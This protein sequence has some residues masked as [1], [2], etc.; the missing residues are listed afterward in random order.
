MGTVVHRVLPHLK[1]LSEF[2]GGS[3]AACGPDAELSALDE[4]DTNGTIL[5][6]DHLVA[7]QKRDQV[8]GWFSPTGGEPLSSILNDLNTYEHVH[9]IKYIPYSDN[10]DVAAIHLALQ[11]FAGTYPAVLQVVNAQALTGNEQNVHSHFVSPEGIDSN[12]GYYI[13]NGDDIQALPISR[14]VT[15]YPGRWIGWG[16]IANAKPAGL[17]VFGRNT[18]NIP[19]GWTDDGTTLKA[20][21][22]IPV[23]KGFRDW[24]LAHAWDSINVPLAPE[25]TITTGSI[26][27]GNPSIGPGSRQ[28]FLLSS[29]GWTT[30]KNV[31]LI[32][33][34]QDLEALKT[35]LAAIKP[36]DLSAEITE[37]EDVIAKLKAV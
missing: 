13:L 3:R 17:I 35:Q 16:S 18:V 8:K 19:T 36:P 37:L 22:G 23:V 11:E 12:L 15:T 1:S 6:A 4:L 7:I 24:I 21:N 9:I 20:P 30:S 27:P 10:P 28:D 31:Y 25:Y 14:G 5:D 33:I 26:E 34:G 32:W 2:I 29:L